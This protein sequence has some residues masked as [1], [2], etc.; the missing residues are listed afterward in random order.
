MLGGSVFLYCQGKSP[1]AN[2]QRLQVEWWRSGYKLQGKK[3]TTVKSVMQPKRR[4]N[5]GENEMG[6]HTVH[7]HTQTSAAF[8][9][10]PWIVVLGW[11]VRVETGLLPEHSRATSVQGSSG[12]SHPNIWSSAKKHPPSPHF[13]CHCLTSTFLA[14]SLFFERYNFSY[15]S[16]LVSTFSSLPPAEPLPHTRN[17]SLV[18]LWLASYTALSLFILSTTMS[19]PSLLPL[20]LLPP[21]SLPS[22]SPPLIS[23]S[24]PS[25]R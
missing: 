7:V 16:L 23:P 21:L 14:L 10:L 15:I 3:Q 25:V 18:S 24:S 8:G 13:V 17:R 12:G 20:P 19:T 5:K 9:K 6:R 22:P 1:M 4:M 11:E 2:Q